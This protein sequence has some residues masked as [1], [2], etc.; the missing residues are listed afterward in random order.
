MDS[1]FLK[2]RI[3]SAQWSGEFAWQN[4]VIAANRWIPAIRIN[5]DIFQALTPI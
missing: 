3:D 5:T 4:A 2:Q 1:V